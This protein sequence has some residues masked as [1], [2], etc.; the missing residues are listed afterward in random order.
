V[1]EGVGGAVKHVYQEYSKCVKKYANNVSKN[2]F[3]VLK[4]CDIYLNA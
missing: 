3:H 4:I 1:G 2:M